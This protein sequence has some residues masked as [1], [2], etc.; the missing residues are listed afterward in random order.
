MNL[1][2]HSCP[3]RLQRNRGL[4]LVELMIAIALGAVLLLGVLQIFA[5]NQ[6]T[7]RTNDEL[8]R[9]Q[10][11][12]RIGL[13]VI[14]RDLRQAGGTSCL[15]IPSTD[16]RQLEQGARTTSTVQVIMGNDIVGFDNGS[17]PVMGGGD[18][19]LAGTDGVL[20]SRIDDCSATLAGNMSA[21]NANIQ[22]TP[23]ALGCGF[24]AGDTLIIS[25]CMSADIFRASNVS[26]G[27]AITT[28]AH[29]SNVNISN[30][31]SKAYQDDASVGRYRTVGY[32]IAMRNGRPALIQDL[33]NG[34]AN[35]ILAEGV[36]NMQILY[37]I[38]TGGNLAVDNL[39]PASTITD[40]TRVVSV[41]LNLL[42]A[43]DNASL[44]PAAQTYDWLADTATVVAPL[45]AADLRMYR[46][47]SQTITLR[48]RAP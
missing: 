20:I 41:N 12:A 29:A 17:Y 48:N 19:P 42:M 36:Q 25:D 35:P 24:Q 6:R 2:I 23:D 3:G 18:T 15:R 11:N 10:E 45:T 33:G 34:T 21:A 39:A 44:L 22:L 43:S 30:E 5:S 4:T 38:D 32:Y 9:I 8:A 40:W 46:P 7:Y 28:V 26:Q 13:E 37:G 47:F 27:V 1:S 31:L 14:A 16:L